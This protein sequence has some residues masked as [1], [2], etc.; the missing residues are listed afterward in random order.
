DEKDI[1]DKIPSFLSGRNF[2]GIILSTPTENDPK[3]N[4]VLA[5]IDIP[6]APINRELPILQSGVVTD[7]YSSVKKSFDYLHSIGHE[8]IA[9]ITGNEYIRP[10][11]EAIDA[12][13]DITKQNKKKY[14]KKLIKS[15]KLSSD[16]GEKILFDMAEEIKNGE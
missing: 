15:G 7:Y 6:I 2:D 9:L 3:L 11:K 5:N 13:R 1:D 4:Q 8:N 14:N 12:Y 16:M 10:T